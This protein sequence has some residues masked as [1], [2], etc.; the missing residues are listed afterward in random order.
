MFDD[1]LDDEFDEEETGDAG[2]AIGIDLG[3]TNSVVSCVVNGEAVV[4][5]DEEGHALQPSVVAWL[6]NG[7]PRVGLAARLRRVIDPANTV[8]S[9]KRIIGKSFRSPATQDVIGQLPYRIIEGANEQP[10]IATRGGELSVPEVSS[11][12]LSRLRSLAEG[13]LGQP[14]TSCVVTVPANF[15][16][17][18]RMATRKAAELAGMDVLRILNEP[19]AAAVAYGRDRDVHRRI[20]IFDLGGG[21]FDVTL[22]AVRESLYEVLA[23]GGDPFLG[24]DDVDHKVRDWL[25]YEFLK[26]HRLDPKADPIALARLSVAAEQIKMQLSSEAVVEGSLSEVML[27]EGGAPLGLDFRLTRDDFEDMIGELVERALE[28]TANVL[29]EAGVSPDRVDEIILVGGSTRVPI[30]ARR[31]EEFFGQ[32]ARLDINP[33]HVVAIGAALQAHNLMFPDQAAA[34]GQSATLLDVTPHSLGL[35]T[36]GG[37]AEHLIPKNTTVPAEGRKVFSTGRDNQTRALIKVCQG[38]SRRFAENSE[39]GTLT[40]DQLPERPRGDVQVEVAFLID[41]D[42]VVQVEARDIKYGS[43]ARATL[44]AIGVDDAGAAT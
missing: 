43:S 12:V 15:S 44:S 34:A 30:I 37:Y 10:I 18:Q 33:M 22:L 2:A 41:A 7:E 8:Y 11:M 13:F 4:I 6:P 26:T 21:T 25:A 38:E 19:T 16:N 36:A 1:L 42:G 3:T 31:V 20:A 14:V 28:T 5:S 23:T 9:A 24:G 39:L 27:G 29:E 40:L 17:G 35:A 32:E